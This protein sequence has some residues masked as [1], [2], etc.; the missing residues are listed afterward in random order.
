MTADIRSAVT[1]ALTDVGADFSVM[2]CD[3][4][5]ADTAQFCEHYGIPPDQSANAIVLASK[6]PSGVHAM[7]LVLATTRLDVN[8]MG[9]QLMDV[10]KV[11]FASSEVTSAVTGMVAGGVTPFGRPH[12]LPLFVD[13]AVMKP[14]WVIVGG[15]SRDMKVKVNPEV[16]TRLEG[17]SIIDGLATSGPDAA[18]TVP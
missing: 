18:Q 12:D 4:D 17:T 13:A 9:R 5:L 15:G 2:E 1:R 10:K 16:F 6:R 3:P 14:E 8:R 11:S 7:F